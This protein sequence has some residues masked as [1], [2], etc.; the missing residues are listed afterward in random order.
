MD[1]SLVGIVI[2]P[3]HEGYLFPNKDTMRNNKYRFIKV[4]CE[5]YLLF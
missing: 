4:L 3:G 5:K 1:K 2:D